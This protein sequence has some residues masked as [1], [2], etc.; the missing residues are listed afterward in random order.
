MKNGTNQ[1]EAKWTQSISVGDKEFLMET[2]AKLGSRA[3]GRKVKGNDE[4]FE[5]KE[6][7]SPYNLVFSPEK[8]GLRLKNDYLWQ[9][10]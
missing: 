3:F 1:R 5:L 4:G 2:K 10:S 6:T 7:Q 9:V 8:F